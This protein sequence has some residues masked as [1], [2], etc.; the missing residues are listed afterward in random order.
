MK[1]LIVED[2]FT[3]RKLLQVYLS[4]Y[5]DCF[6]AVNG[7]EAVQ[8]VQGAFEENLPYDLICLDILM[9]EMDGYETLK[10]IRQIEK[11]QGIDEADRVKV[12][13][14]T[15]LSDYD[16]VTKA[17]RTGCESYIVKPVTKESLLREI[18]KLGLLSSG[19]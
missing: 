17:F 15:V 4:D 19:E 6:V 10:A 12:I 8:A 5:G 3:A 14:T 9:P 11:E 2:D 16:N 1:C 18:E 7:N 13:M